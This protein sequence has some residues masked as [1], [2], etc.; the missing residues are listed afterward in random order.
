MKARKIV[1]IILPICLLAAILVMVVV[2]ALH[3]KKQEKVI[4]SSIPVVVPETTEPETEPLPEWYTGNK[5]PLTGIMDLP[6][7]A[8]GKK[9]VA[10]M[11][12]NVIDAMPQYGIEDADIMFEI[13]VESDLTRMMAIYPD[14]KALKDICSVR[15]CRYYF[16]AMAAGF[17]ALYIH[18]GLDLTIADYLYSLDIPKYDLN[19]EFYQ[20]NLAGRDQDRLDKGYLLEHTSVFHGK[21]LPKFLKQDGVKMKINKKRSG[22]AFKFTDSEEPINPSKK[23]CTKVEINFGGQS[24][25][26][27]YDPETKTY[28]KKNCGKKQIDEK[29]GN[30]LAFTNLFVL[31]TDIWVRED[32]YHKGVDWNGGKK[33]KGYYI[34]NGYIREI[35]WSK[36]DEYSKL[37]ILTKAGNEVPVN[38]G[39]S[40]IALTYPGSATFKG[41]KKN[42]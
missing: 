19:A 8:V 41:E 25:Q 4:P 5:N 31:E 36:K 30:Q 24:T 12:N 32:G 26:F 18:W 35:R 7:E 6:D 21:K 3:G 22:D 42:P 23:S 27:K 20:G 16:P 10:V 40:Y 9:P 17:D 34:S 37:K 29:T 28:K 33:A 1:Q 13:P 38:K 39:K 14:Y 15:S 11:I 2:L